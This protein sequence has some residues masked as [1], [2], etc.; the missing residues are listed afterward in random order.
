MKIIR[1]KSVFRASLFFILGFILPNLLFHYFT[2]IVTEVLIER[3]LI[4]AF[5]VIM[6]AIFLALINSE[7]VE[8][9][10]KL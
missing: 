7:E 3:F 1:T 5:T 4:Q 2:S 8:I 10:E 9:K 6:F